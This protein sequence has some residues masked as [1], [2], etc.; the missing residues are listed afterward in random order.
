MKGKYFYPTLLQSSNHVESHSWFNIC[1]RKNLSY[2]KKKKKRTIDVSYIYTMKI[3][4]NL[5]EKQKEIIN[6]WLDDCIKIYNMTNSYIKKNITD[7]NN[8]KFLIFRELRKALLDDTRAICNVN[9]LGKHTADYAIKHCMEMYKSAISNKKLIAKFNIKDLKFDKRKKNLVIEPANVSKKTNSFFYEQLKKINSSMRLKYITSNSILQYDKIKHSYII[10]S[11]KEKK[12]IKKI[13]QNGTCAIDIGCRTFLTTYSHKEAFEIGTS[14]FTYHVIDNINK[15]LDNI[16]SSYD[17]KIINKN[18]YEKI[19]GKYSDKLKNK[20]KE[21]H[22]KASNYLLSRYQ[23]I[24]IGK[25]SISNMISKLEG[26]LKEITKRRLIALSHYKFR[27]KLIEMA[28]KFGSKIVL[29]S[30]YMTSKTCSRCKNI[31]SNL[32]S[33]KIYIC[34]KC[35]LTIDRDINASINIYDKYEAKK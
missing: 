25:V 6:K 24:I 15:R 18:K 28:E 12:E 26:N 27:M 11:P 5:D 17:N 4:L 33:E 9:K 32:T 3:K 35:N 20:I 13:E 34:D 2:N 10:I 30:E 19:Y 22:N 29:I 23:I 21:L 1:E 16:K 31:K 7:E 14:N 8:K